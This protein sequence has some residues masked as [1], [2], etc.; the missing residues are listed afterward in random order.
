MT[1]AELPGMVLGFFLTILILSYLLLD[2]NLLFRLGAHLLVGVSAGYLLA[3]MFRTI[4]YE[5]F[6]VPLIRDPLPHLPGMILLLLLSALLFLRFF[7]R[8]TILT[9]LPMA[10]LVGVGAAVVVGG[11]LTGTFLPQAVVTAEPSLLPMDAQRTFDFAAMLEN[12]C[13]LLGTLSTLIY[14]HFGASP[15]GG[16]APTYPAF[17]RPIA[18]VGRGVLMVTLGVLYAGALLSSLAVFVDRMMAL[19]STIL[20]AAGGSL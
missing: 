12:W 10:F 2:D 5:Q 20:V 7:T 19:V 1:T 18:L 3:V 15:R 17:V 16:G 4:F 14:F 9:T 13:V 11:S 6:I 8:G